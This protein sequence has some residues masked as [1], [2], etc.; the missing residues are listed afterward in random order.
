MIAGHS[1]GGV[2]ANQLMQGYSMPYRL[3]MVFGSYVTESGPYDLT[4]YPVPVLTL[5]AQLDGLTSPGK[6]TIWWKQFIS[7]SNSNPNTFLDK[8]V[9]VLPLQNHSDFC[10]GYN[11]P[12]DI[13][14]E[15]SPH[16][17]P[18]CVSF[19]PN[20]THSFPSSLALSPRA[21]VGNFCHQEHWKVRGCVLA[22]PTAACF[23]QQR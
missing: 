10:P 1:L 13:M 18:L 19:I 21:G 3:I 6:T 11:V 23:S 2:C 8:P 17:S 12:G 16:P 15:V 4:N 20:P 22:H 9:I 14:A 5:N 7:M